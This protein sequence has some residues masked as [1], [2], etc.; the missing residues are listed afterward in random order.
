MGNVIDW[1]ETFGSASFEQAGRLI[2][3]CLCKSSPESAHD[4][5]KKLAQE[6]KSLTPQHC[7]ICVERS[8][9]NVLALARSVY[10]EVR[11]D[12]SKH[13]RLHWQTF[14]YTLRVAL[15]NITSNPIAHIHVITEHLISL[16]RGYVDPLHQRFLA[17]SRL[18]FL[19]T[20]A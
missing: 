8:L 7:D 2:E 4:R 16:K 3:Y 20:L 15:K 18:Y 19:E 9:E 10:A 13:A 12:I 11:P 5:I 14:F 17:H 6:I 1:R